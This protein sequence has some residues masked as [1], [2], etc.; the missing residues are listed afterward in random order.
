M[1]RRFP[2]RKRKKS[3]F[4]LSRNHF[5]L[6]SLSLPSTRL[7]CSIE[8]HRRNENPS[9][10]RCY[11]LKSRI[12]G[13]LPHNVYCEE[14][15]THIDDPNRGGFTASA[16]I[17][18]A[19]KWFQT[20]VP[21]NDKAIFL[22][23]FKGSLDLIEGILASQFGID[24]V[25]YDGDVSKEVRTSD[26]ERFK[27]SSTCRVLLATVQ[28]GGT[29][30]NITEANH[31]CFLDRW[32]NPCVHDQ[33]ESR[34]HR[35]GQ[36]KDVNIAYLDINFTIDV[37]MKRINILKE[38][39]ANVIL[40][41]GT[42]LG[43]RWSLGYRNV[44][45]VIGNTLNALRDMRDQAIQSN[46]DDPLPPYVESDLEE[47]L[48]ATTKPKAKSN[49]KN[50]GR[51]HKV[52]PETERFPVTPSFSNHVDLCQSE[53][54]KP[55]FSNYV[56]LCM[57]EGPKFGPEFRNM[58]SETELRLATLPRTATTSRSITGHNNSAYYNEKITP[59]ATS[60]PNRPPGGA[61]DWKASSKV[62]TAS[63]KL[64][65]DASSRVLS[66]NR[67]ASKLRRPNSISSRGKRSVSTPTATQ[68][69]PKR[70]RFSR[71]LSS[72]V[73]QKKRTKEFMR[74]KSRG[75]L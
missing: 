5:F 61:G 45:G 60:A 29:G 16:K 63:K 75:D 11:D 62:W 72:I 64:F 36:K 50:E 56:D 74:R 9:C 35:I 52:K 40:A 69:P 47:K 73:S 65:R 53:A 24:C 46:G 6:T 23:F 17:E 54:S 30:L 48:A 7:V 44:S 58:K 21:K 34:C 51:E 25:R 68:A 20:T 42:S 38:G 31:V 3:G 67:H 32:F 13:K 2:E 33:A 4:D 70:N 1:S 15:S 37:V 39:N 19:I 22:S 41:D 43:D 26:L 8:A 49:V 59:L 18:D 14:I 27:T 71:G 10:P 55:S 28:S 12:H 66:E 57:S